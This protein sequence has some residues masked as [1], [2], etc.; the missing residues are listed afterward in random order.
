MLGS[1]D[2]REQEQAAGGLARFSAASADSKVEIA[3]AG[4]IPSLVV[5]LRPHATAGV[6]LQ[7]AGAL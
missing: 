7:A 2:S 5:L 6:Q 3:A 1:G 4:A